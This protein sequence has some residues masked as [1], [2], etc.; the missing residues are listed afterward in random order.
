VPRTIRQGLCEIAESFAP[1]L[2]TQLGYRTRPTLASPQSTRSAEAILACL[3]QA[4]SP[5]LVL[6]ETGGVVFCNLAFRTETLGE[7]APAK[8]EQAHEASP[9][10]AARDVKTEC[11]DN[12]QAWLDSSFMPDGLLARIQVHQFESETERLR[13]FSIADRRIDDYPPLRH[14]TFLHNVLNSAGGIEMLTELLTESALPSEIEEQ[15]QL[16]HQGVKRLMVQVRSQQILVAK[17]KREADGGTTGTPG[18]LA[19]KAELKK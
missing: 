13:C 2:R 3:N 16:L 14:R 4:P 8:S 18:R 15:V 17:L 11:R 5:I 12:A 9:H 19:R 6:D 1:A 7:V 10:A